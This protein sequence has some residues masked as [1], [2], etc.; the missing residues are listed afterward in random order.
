M[1]LTTQL[2]S[3][4]PTP[5]PEDN[6]SEILANIRRVDIAG[7]EPSSIRVHLFEWT[8]LALG[9]YESLLWGFIFSCEMLVSKGTA[10]VWNGTLVKLFRVQGMA[11]QAPSLYA[12]RGAVDALG[13]N[14]V[15]RIGSL[16][17]G[18]NAQPRATP[19]SSSNGGQ[20]YR[21]V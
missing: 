5:L 7:I 16:R 21:E 12:P 8:P 4:L 15:H 9:W 3:Q 1:T 11:A 18:G 13:S 19:P 20:A 2:Q 14:I 10:G 17:L 6:I